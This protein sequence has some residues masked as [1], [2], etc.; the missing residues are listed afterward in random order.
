ME[1]LENLS[2]VGKDFILEANPMLKSLNGLNSLTTI[3]RLF[4]IYNNPSLTNIDGLNKLISLST[5]SIQKN[6]LLSNFCSLQNLINN[7]GLTGDYIVSENSL[8]PS[9]QNI[10]TGNCSNLGKTQPKI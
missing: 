9:M 6:S 10:L 3:D 5:L 7:N 1:G 8:N 4:S 2:S